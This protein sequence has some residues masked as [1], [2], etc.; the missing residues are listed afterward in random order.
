MK[1]YLSARSLYLV[2]LV[3]VLGVNIL[4]VTGALGNRRGTPEAQV[5][6]T[7]RELAVPGYS[8]EENSG[9]ALALDWRSLEEPSRD[10]E[11]PGHWGRPAW[12]GAAKLEELGFRTEELR[13]RPREGTYRRPLSKE[14]FIVLEFDGE[15]YREALNRAAA[16]L[17]RAAATCP[18]GCA[19]KSKQEALEK[20]E[21]RLARERISASR[22][23]AVDAGLDPLRL[24]GAYSDRARFIVTPGIVDVWRQ[25]R[26]QIRGHITGLSVSAIHVPLEFKT[27]L[28]SLPA[29]SFSTEKPPPAPRYEVDLAYGSRLEPWI[30]HIRRLEKE[31]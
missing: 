22:L 7:E 21:T 28:E 14:V 6:L 1:T 23:F 11:I 9:L 12:F 4:V 31:G 19:E 8:R 29:T 16:A 30:N 25:E 18:A 26:D 17:V 13:E 2:G 15:A 5:T 20:A 24:R 3:L 10:D 27:L